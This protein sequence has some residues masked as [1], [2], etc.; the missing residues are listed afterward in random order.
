[1]T[2]NNFLLLT[3]ILLVSNLFA[4][5]EKEKPTVYIELEHERG[6]QNYY[7]LLFPKEFKETDFDGASIALY[8]KEEILVSVGMDTTLITPDREFLFNKY[9]HGYI[10]DMWIAKEI[11][12]NA[13]ITI[14]YRMRPNNNG[15]IPAC[16][17]W[18]EYKFSELER[19][20]SD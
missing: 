6:N 12:P 17:D 7:Y 19:I 1:M 8:E 16:V 5:G 13:R 9:G 10:S 4:C 15:L 18:F 14:A 3:S 2:I 11:E 20:E